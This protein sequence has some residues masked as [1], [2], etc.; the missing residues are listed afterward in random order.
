M[1]NGSV[2]SLL[3]PPFENP[4]RRLGHY[5]LLVFKLGRIVFQVY[6]FDRQS[7]PRIDPRPCTVIEHLIQWI[8]TSL[9]PEFGRGRV[10]YRLTPLEDVLHGHGGNEAIVPWRHMVDVL[11]A[12]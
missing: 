8:G 5:R 9:I 7:G 6:L 4:A 3:L 11:L 12:Q 1:L 10:L 2:R